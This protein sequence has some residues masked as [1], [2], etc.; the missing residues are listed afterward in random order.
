MSVNAI[1][2][3]SNRNQ[4][5]GPLLSEGAFRSLTQ[6]VDMAVLTSFEEA[7]LDGVPDLIV[8]LIDL[9]LE[10]APHR[11]AA[12][13]EALTRKDQRALKQAAHCLK[14]SSAN[15]GA[16]QVALICEELERIECNDWFP[17][18]QA[19]LGC[20]EEEFARVRQVLLAERRRR[21]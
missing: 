18:V 21:S 15:L 4:E 19:L 12:I 5:P 2:N 9:Y 7:Q 10:D 17:G 11:L 16:L 3:E 8:E 13:E 14:G 1:G 20:L 6:A